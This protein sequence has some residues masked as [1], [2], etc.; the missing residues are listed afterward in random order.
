MSYDPRDQILVVANNAATPPYITMISTRPDDRRVLGH[1]IYS[2]A[3]GVEQSVYN[4][5]TGLFYVNLTQVGP[6][7]NNGAV[8]IVDPRQLKETGRFSVTG[9]NGAG[10]A[11][12]PRQ[13][14]LVGCSLTNNSQII[15]A[16]DGGLLATIPQV[17]GSDEVWYNPGDGNFYLAARNNPAAAGGPSLGVIDG[18]SNK[19]VTNV[20][21]RHQRPFGRGGS[22]DQSRLRPVR[23]GRERCVVHVGVH[24]RLC[25]ARGRRRTGARRGGFRRGPGSLT[26]PDAGI[27]ADRS[28]SGRSGSAWMPDEP[29]APHTRGTT[30]FRTSPKARASR[31]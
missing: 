19:F 14:L 18:F 30:G 10:L 2:D 13:Q 21:D 28:S 24:L 8:S 15:S 29:T 3:A 7:P 9:C 23:P 27:L 1:V 22:Q 12:G 20:P 26:P 16:R 5:V 25:R 31:S 4:P 11:L 17:S 6:D